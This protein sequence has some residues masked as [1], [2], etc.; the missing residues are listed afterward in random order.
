M[1]VVAKIFIISVIALRLFSQE[2]LIKTE[3]NPVY[4]NSTSQG[5]R[6]QQT[7]GQLDTIQLPFYDDFRNSDYKVSGNLWYNSNNIT[8]FHYGSKL[9]SGSFAMLDGCDSL[10]LPY[11]P[12]L[13]SYGSSDTLTSHCIDL[14]LLNPSDSIYLSFWI[15]NGGVF[16]TAE[17]SDSI[18]LAFRDTSDFTEVWRTT[19]D[20]IPTD[21]SIQIL[22]PVADS[23]FFNKCF[24]FNFIRI[25][26]QNGRFDNYLISEVYLDK[27]RNYKDSLYTISATSITGSPFGKFYHI[28]LRQFKAMAIDS[29]RPIDYT[30][31]NNTNSPA[32][33]TATVNIYDN[34]N[35]QIN[36]TNSF[37]VSL[38]GVFYDTISIGSPL[39]NT[40][41]N[42]AEI[43]YEFIY[44]NDTL[45]S[46]FRVD[47]VWAYDDGSAEAGYG[48]YQDQSFGQEFTL[49]QPDSLRAIYIS[50]FPT[51]YKFKD[52]TFV[53]QVWRFKAGVPDS[54]LY[55]RNVKL[56]TSEVPNGFY[57]YVLDSV[58]PL[59]TK[60]LIAVRQY[61]SNPLS[62]GFDKSHS[63][64]SIWFQQNGN[65][66]RSIFEGNL[67]MRAEL[68][69]GAK[70]KLVAN[71]AYDKNEIKI[72]P[73]PAG[74]FVRIA[75][76]YPNLYWE[77]YNVLGEKIKVGKTTTINI[78][79][80]PQGVYFIKLANRFYKIIKQ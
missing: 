21:S 27:N 56:K 18:I 77:L 1:K 70:G 8:V 4:F 66:K 68:Q 54:V 7:N 10:N 31:F 47:S 23:V 67:L 30:F 51:Q 76:N 40:I 38:P 2:V 17:V 33:I 25:G 48:I 5:L 45:R 24:Q 59:P 37:P 28:P 16:D 61:D 11:V 58:L 73:N 36:I 20:Q 9:P 80:L 75:S 19:G 44:N 52:K 62:V 29:L 35:N 12:L 6:Q 53:L 46:K 41:N 42:T 15:Q 50:F 60:F 71:I 79:N 65:W 14:S 3:Q 32:N 72:F 26:S 69:G 78:A 34:I 63:P 22:I 43:N 39:L 49:L 64:N 57:R 55:Q 13:Q 74:D